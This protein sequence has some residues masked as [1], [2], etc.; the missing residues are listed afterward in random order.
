MMNPLAKISID[1]IYCTTVIKKQRAISE[2]A[3]G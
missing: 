2:E 3:E 1:T